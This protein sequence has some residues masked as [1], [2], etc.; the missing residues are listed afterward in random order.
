MSTILIVDDEPEIIRITRGYLEQ[1]GYEVLAANDGTHALQLFRQNQPDLVILDLN[2]PIAVGGQPLDGLDVAR[3]I[4]QMPPPMGQIPIIM[5]TARVEE[6][7]RIIG[8]E[9]GADDYVPKPFS[10]RELVARVRAVLRRVTPVSSSPAQ[11][12]VGSLVIDFIRHTVTVNGRSAN[13]TPTEFTLL[14]AMA[15]E[16][17][18]A[19]TRGQLVNLLGIDYEGLE[20]TVDSHIKNLRAKIEPDPGEPQFILTVFGVGYKFNETI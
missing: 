1:A 5:L 15:A 7:D 12:K 13:L 8:L 18:R 11:I 16:P 9:L 2:L 20:R 10:P 19:F 4:R 17:G 6:T 14:Q 3:S